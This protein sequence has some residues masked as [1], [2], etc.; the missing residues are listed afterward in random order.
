MKLQL[1]GM[2][3]DDD[4]P[5]GVKTISQ[6]A[7]F[8][9]QIFKLNDYKS[10]YGLPPGYNRFFSTNNQFITDSAKGRLRLATEQKPWDK[11]LAEKGQY[12]LK[13]EIT[14]KLFKDSANNNIGPLGFEEGESLYDNR[15][16][17]RG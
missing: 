4:A 3:D 1:F 17:N 2:P 11:L 10:N 6:F 9:N 12:N 16:L 13:R 15:L 8:I 14:N 7:Y 5:T